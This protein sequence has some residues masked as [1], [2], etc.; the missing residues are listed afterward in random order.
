ML[1][2]IT[3]GENIPDQAVLLGVPVFE[4]E[5]V[6]SK[7]NLL[8]LGEAVDASYIEQLGFTAKQDET[9]MLTLE[10]HVCLLV[11]LGSREEF[12]ADALRRSGA[13]FVRSLRHI[14]DVAF[15][16]PH[17]I[18]RLAGSDELGGYSLRRGRVHLA[19]SPPLSADD[20]SADDLS[21]DDLSAGDHGVTRKSRASS[22]TNEGSSPLDWQRSV[23]VLSEGMLL[24]AYSFTRLKSHSEQ[25]SVHSIQIVVEDVA[26]AELGLS[27][28]QLMAGACHLSG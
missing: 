6:A 24:A 1:L 23:Q 8:G 25:E 20:L 26:S 7:V 10:N 28:A 3:V 27:K 4:G 11:G 22:S 15:L 14:S 18:A 21:A 13:S 9:L 19:S 5:S 16:L 17:E 12:C 2:N